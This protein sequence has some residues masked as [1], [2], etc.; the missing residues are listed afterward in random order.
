[1][2]VEP[3]NPGECNFINSVREGADIVRAIDAPAIR[4]LAD[5]FHMAR[6]E[7]TPADLAAVCD[8]LA[9]VHIAERES[10]AHRRRRRR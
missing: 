2:V 7:E 5:L 6:A 1:V 3:S 9:H 10:R 8:L 4:L